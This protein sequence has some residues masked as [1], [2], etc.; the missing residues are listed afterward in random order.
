MEKKGV[1]EDQNKEKEMKKK[2]DTRDLLLD[3]REGDRLRWCLRKWIPR[4][5]CSDPYVSYTFRFDMWVTNDGRF[6]SC[7]R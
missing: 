1:P 4:S 2:G 6:S 3:V 5:G 7:T